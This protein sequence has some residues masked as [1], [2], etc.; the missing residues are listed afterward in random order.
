MHKMN[1]TEEEYKA[2]L[3]KQRNAQKRTIIKPNISKVISP[4]IQ[5]K[6]VPQS[7]RAFDSVLS[8]TIPLAPISKKNSQQILINSKTKRP[9]IMPSK[10]YKQYE[11]ECAKYLPK[12]EK[13]IDFPVNI[14]CLYFMST[15]RKCDLTNLM[16]S[17]HDI[18]VHC[19][20]LSDDN[21]SIVESVDGSQIF[22]DKENPR[23]EIII[24]RKRKESNDT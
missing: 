19:G 5:N 20:I 3:E 21:Y 7:Q 24:T 12:I 23:T 6:P 10:Q 15:K 17:T 8:F 9:F 11:K 13:P 14:K 4:T 22:Y 18:M 1:W 16:E 2:F